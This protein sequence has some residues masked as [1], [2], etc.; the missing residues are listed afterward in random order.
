MTNTLTLQ[1]YT[2][3]STVMRFVKL[4]SDSTMFAVFAILPLQGHVIMFV[5]ALLV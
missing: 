1:F 5:W 2:R 3:A 4:E